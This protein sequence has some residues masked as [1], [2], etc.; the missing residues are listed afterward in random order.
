MTGT[1]ICYENPLLCSFSLQLIFL[2]RTVV[3]RKLF[4]IR[5]SYKHCNFSRR[6]LLVK[7]TSKTVIRPIN[8]YWLCSYRYS[9]AISHWRQPRADRLWTRRGKRR[10][11]HSWRLQNTSTNKRL[12]YK[13]IFWHRWKAYGGMPQHYVWKVIR[14]LPLGVGCLFYFYP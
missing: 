13:G 1:K 8:S 14:V 3:L 10:H 11:Y 7:M 9:T 5:F 6:C 4:D 2:F 12:G